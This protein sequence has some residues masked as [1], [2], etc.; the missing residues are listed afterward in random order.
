MCKP[1]AY[2]I[3]PL[4]LISYIRNLHAYKVYCNAGLNFTKFCVYKVANI[5][6]ECLKER[7]SLLNLLT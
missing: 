4:H 2:A 1:C 3:T 7:Y 6:A 5:I